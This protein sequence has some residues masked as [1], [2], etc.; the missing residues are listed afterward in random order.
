M[1]G[2]CCL[3]LLVAFSDAR[4]YGVLKLERPESYSF[5]NTCVIKTVVF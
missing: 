4:C 5:Y 1:L 2:I 3:D